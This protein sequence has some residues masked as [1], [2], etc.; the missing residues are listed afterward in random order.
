M[1]NCLLLFHKIVL[2]FHCYSYSCPCCATFFWFCDTT[3]SGATFINIKASSILDKY[4]GESDKLVSAIFSLGRKLA[5]SV[6]FID[7]IETVLKKRGSGPF[8][9]QQIQSM[10][11]NRKGAACFTNCVF[12]ICE[13]VILYI[14][15]YFV[16]KCVGVHV[17]RRCIIL[18]K[19]HIDKLARCFMFRHHLG[20]LINLRLISSPCLARACSFL[21]GTA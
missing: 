3:E 18:L 16:D 1:Q 20:F 15:A 14:C 13:C 2:L 10:Q 5:P 17:C 21:S 9:S 6:I 4:L 12:L 11:V 7:E 8:D 19:K